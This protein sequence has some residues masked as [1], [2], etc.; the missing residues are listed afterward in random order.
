MKEAIITDLHGYMTDV[1]L[2]A[3]AVSGV[4]PIYDGPV[5]E[6]AEQEKNGGKSPEGPEEVDPS[7][8]GYTVAVPVPP[9]LYKPRFDIEAWK[10]AG[11]TAEERESSPIDLTSLW[12]EGLTAEE[13]DELR[14]RPQPTSPTDLLGQEL[15][16]MKLRNMRQQA[17]IDGLGKEL[18]KAKI[19]MIEIKGGRTA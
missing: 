1:T 10:A 4:F 14:N 11:Q 15:A 17:V 19:E 7:H 18:T 5:E 12:N 16:L 9:G 8:I 13:I 2:V 3:D 6:V